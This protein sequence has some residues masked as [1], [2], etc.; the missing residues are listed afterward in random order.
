MKKMRDLKI[1]IQGSLASFHDLAAKK[2][3]GDENDILCCGS[4]REVCERLQGNDVDYG[5]IAIE[6]KVAGSIL[7]NY[8]LIEQFNLNI[9]GETY[10]PISLGLYA[11]KGCKESDI[12]EIVSHPMALGQCQNYLSKI[13]DVIVTEF[14]DTATSAKLVNSQSQC[15]LAVIAGPAVGTAYEL[16]CLIPNVCD[17]TQ[18]YTR[19]YVLTKGEDM[20]EEPNKASINIVTQHQIGALAD[21]LIKI[22]EYGVNL[23]KIQSVPIPNIHNHY[24]MHLDLEFN[25]KT[26]FLK[27]IEELKLLVSK[28]KVLGIYKSEETIFSQTN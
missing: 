17:E 6:N 26:I 9:I 1:A 3:F 4:F 25:D 19:F 8:Q 21:V 14:K 28:V 12:K 5:V 7:L 20:I 16:D 22:K 11:K 18:N 13:N 27:L 10:L 2:F 15:D 24:M 23:S